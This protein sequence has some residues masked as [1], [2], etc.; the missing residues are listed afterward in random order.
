[1]HQLQC[2]NRNCK[3]DFSLPQWKVWLLIVGWRLTSIL[4][5]LTEHTESTLA[6]LNFHSF[7]GV[8]HILCCWWG[9]LLYRFGPDWCLNIQTMFYHTHTEALGK[10][11]HVI[12]ETWVGQESMLYPQP[13][14]YATTPNCTPIHLKIRSSLQFPVFH[15][16]SAVWDKVISH[17]YNTWC[18]EAMQ[19]LH[20]HDVFWIW[21]CLSC[22]FLRLN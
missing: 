21:H 14:S 6:F 10:V 3:P 1:M 15:K 19:I 20:Q 2:Q 7:S 11:W 22:N 5:L 9:L 17:I 8:S 12:S 4:V 13:A 16:V 18:P